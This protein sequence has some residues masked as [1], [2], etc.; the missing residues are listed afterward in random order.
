MFYPGKL[1]GMDT[2]VP[3]VRLYYMR[4]GIEDYDAM[5]DLRENLYGAMS[6]KYGAT[7]NADGILNELYASMYTLNK[8]YATSAELATS[9]KGLETLLVW[10]NNGI[11]VSDFTL[12]ADG[13]ATAKIHAPAN[14]E[15]KVNGKVLTGGQT[16]GEGVVYTVSEKA[17]NFVIEAAGMSVSVFTKTTD[18]F[19]TYTQNYTLY[20]VADNKEVIDQAAS[21]TVNNG[22][23][24]VGLKST[25]T[26]LNYA[27]GKTQLTADSKSLIIVV[28]YSGT[29]RT[30]MSIGFKAQSMLGAVLR[31][32]FDT[33]YLHPG[34][35]VIRID[36]IGDKWS[37][38]KEMKALTF[39]PQ[40]GHSDYTLTIKNIS[41]IG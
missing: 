33:V 39:T 17:E 35:N 1:L 24:A 6:E 12:N 18:I 23:V 5:Y 9:R 16:A 38:L 13:T 2:P 19:S 32:V 34:E 36:R 4:D 20:T 3:A 26:E 11:G 40:D 14:V 25:N 10:A 15:I 8:T 41:V 27:L 22:A 21:I 30:E 7:L 31:G 28:N 37:S 29:E